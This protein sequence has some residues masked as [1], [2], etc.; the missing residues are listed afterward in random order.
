MMSAAVGYGVGLVLGGA[1]AQRYGWRATFMAAGLVGLII[2]PLTQ[3]VLREPRRERNFFNGASS[4]ESSYSAI[5][6]LLAKPAYRSLLL[7]FVVEYFVSYGAILFIASLMIRR[8]GLNIAEAGTIL[9]IVSAGA[10]VI[11]AVSGGAA[12]D[13]LA[14]RDPAW[15]PRVASWTM[16]ASLPA[17]EG[18]L[19]AKSLAIMVP[20]LLLS[21]SLLNA[22]LP[23]MFSSV[24][25]VC[26][27][28][29]RAL[30]IAVVLFFANLLGAG[31]GPVVTGALSDTLSQ[32]IGAIGG[33]RCALM[34][35]GSALCLG[36]WVLLRAGRNF[37]AD[38][39]P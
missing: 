4:A 27:S 39:E 38:M 37:A 12:A 9:G 20:L 1:I 32:S 26:G 33:L 22:S 17:L 3:T 13:R 18:A 11:G 28:S 29:R 7:A 16:L 15:L 24:H 8:Y 21:L 5:R 19:W 31:I 2:A 30:S 25:A 6:S 10:A 34:I 23:A 14:R 36:G 35:V